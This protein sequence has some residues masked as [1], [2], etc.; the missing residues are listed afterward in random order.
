VGEIYGRYGGDIGEIRGVTS[1][2]S[3]GPGSAR[4]RSR[5]P[6]ESGAVLARAVLAGAVL[7]AAPREVPWAGPCG[8]APSGASGTYLG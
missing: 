4:Q 3:H 5:K 8:G 6:E 7:A 1:G 2:V